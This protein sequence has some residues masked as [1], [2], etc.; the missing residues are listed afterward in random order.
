MKTK[1]CKDDCLF[2]SLEFLYFPLGL[3]IIYSM[4]YY[5]YRG[6][7]FPHGGWSIASV[8]LAI[9]FSIIAGLLA[10]CNN[11]KLSLRSRIVYIVFAGSI[12]SALLM[13]EYSPPIYI[14][15]GIG[16]AAISSGIAFFEFSKSSDKKENRLFQ[17]LQFI[18]IG[19]GALIIAFIVNALSVQLAGI[20]MGNATVGIGNETA[21]DLANKANHA[22]MAIASIAAYYFMGGGLMALNT[23]LP[24]KD[25]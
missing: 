25:C 14:V 6:S 5:V 4:R 11:S 16:L 13:L 8:V 24:T 17:V 23:I 7:F 9:I 22:I 1:K 20:G 15:A 19:L 3:G 18:V 12:A 2:R 10:V 21:A